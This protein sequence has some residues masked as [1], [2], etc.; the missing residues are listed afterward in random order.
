[1]LYQHSLRVAWA[2]SRALTRTSMGEA[3]PW[4]PHA[5]VKTLWLRASTETLVLDNFFE[6]FLQKRTQNARAPA[7]KG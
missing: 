1:V 3:W 4:A 6:F 2:F 5:K 7:T